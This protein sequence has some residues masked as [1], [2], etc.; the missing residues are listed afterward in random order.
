M[1]RIDRG[2]NKSQNA[3][4]KVHC[5]RARRICNYISI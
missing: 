2:L 5:V 4:Y 1:C 3:S